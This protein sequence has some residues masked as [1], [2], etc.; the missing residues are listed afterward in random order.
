MPRAPEPP[1]KKKKNSPFACSGSTRCRKFRRKEE[2]S[3]RVEVTSW[4]DIL[5]F[6]LLL[7]VFPNDF[8]ALNATVDDALMAIMRRNIVD[9]IFLF[10]GNIE[11]ILSKSR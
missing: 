5:G 7:C 9:C 2:P 6:I 3:R 1:K 10:F 11:G 4:G 8:K